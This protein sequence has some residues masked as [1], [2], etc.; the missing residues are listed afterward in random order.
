MGIQK[1]PLY[2][3]FSAQYQVNNLNIPIVFQLWVGFKERS[4]RKSLWEVSRLHPENDSLVRVVVDRENTTGLT[5]GR[6]FES[7]IWDIGLRL[8]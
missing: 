8:S 4:N 7:H 6:P 5:L 1:N 3:L 2:V